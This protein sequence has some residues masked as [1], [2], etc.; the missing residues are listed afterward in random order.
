MV[1]PDFAA[2]ARSYGALALTVEKDDEFPSALEA[3]LHA[4][5]PSLIHIK[6]SPEA[7][8]PTTTLSQLRADALAAD[9]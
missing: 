3:A 4:K 8:T 1:N 6:I 5:T 2:L 7:I 9:H